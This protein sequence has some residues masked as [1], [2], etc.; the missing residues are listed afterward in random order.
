MSS[1]LVYSTCLLQKGS[2]EFL[3]PFLKKAG[4]VTRRLFWGTPIY[5]Q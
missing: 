5:L 1:L 2:E 4:R 3:R